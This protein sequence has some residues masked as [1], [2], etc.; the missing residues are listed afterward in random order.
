MGKIAGTLFLMFFLVG[1][2][3]IKPMTL[4]SYNPPNLSHLARPEIPTPVE[5]IDFTIDEQ[6]GKVTYTITGQ[7]KLT[8]MVISEGAAWKT[9]EMLKQMIGIQTEIVN[10]YGQLIITIDLQRQMAER[11]RMT[12][13]I[14][15]WA[16]EI[17]AVILTA[18]TLYK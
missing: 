2:S 4:P 16:V 11:G 17:I 1:C 12:S 7:D 5:G 6:A 3:E 9:V 15:L 13:E 10:Q 8:A 18:L 14:K